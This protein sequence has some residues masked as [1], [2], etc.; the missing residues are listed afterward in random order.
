[1]LTKA[2]MNNPDNFPCRCGFDRI[3]CPYCKNPFTYRELYYNYIR[4][5]KCE[6][7]TKVVWNPK[8]IYSIVDLRGDGCM[9][10]VT[11]KICG[12]VSGLCGD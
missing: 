7:I 1:M 9:H 12:K 2:Q 6:I 3:K 4:C 5:S 10:H 8:G 11:C